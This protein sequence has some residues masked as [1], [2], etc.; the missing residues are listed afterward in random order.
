MDLSAEMEP[1]STYLRKVV[2]HIQ[3]TNICFDYS[4]Y[5]QGDVAT[6]DMVLIPIYMAGIGISSYP[7]YFSSLPEFPHLTRRLKSIGN[8]V[9]SKH[10]GYLSFS[11]H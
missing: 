1:Q 4:S 10:G 3:R 8:F 9:N 6:F 7:I 5:C 11:L 2:A